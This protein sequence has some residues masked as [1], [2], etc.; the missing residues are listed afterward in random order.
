[1]PN[2]CARSSTSAADTRQPVRVATAP[3][4]YRLIGGG[5]AAARGHTSVTREIIADSKR[6]IRRAEAGGSRGFD[7]HHPLHSPLLSRH[8][9]DNERARHDIVLPAAPASRR[10]S[11]HA[12][13]ADCMLQSPVGKAA[14]P[15]DG[16]LA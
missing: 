5:R 9:R 6:L 14:F 12:I 10:S 1:M 15:G 8:V 7:S 13:P 2:Q 4:R 16:T 11:H 3:A